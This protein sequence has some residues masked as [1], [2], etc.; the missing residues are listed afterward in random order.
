M[1]D[2]KYY[3]V[4]LAGGITGFFNWLPGIPFDPIKTNMQKNLRETSMINVAK[5]GYN[6][7]GF[8]FFGKGGGLILLRGVPHS[9]ILFL[10]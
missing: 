2:N 8:R 5:C 1:L 9:S 10:T 4:A 7:E 3:A 6:A